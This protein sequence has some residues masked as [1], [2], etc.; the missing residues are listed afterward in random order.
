[1]ADISKIKLPNGT[2]YD[3]K[4]LRLPG[5][6][7]VDEGKIIAVNSSGNYV[8]AEAPGSANAYVTSTTLYITTG[9]SNGDGVSY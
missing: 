7:S 5:A 3:I 9:I 8:V 1:M 4:D 6:T 2:T